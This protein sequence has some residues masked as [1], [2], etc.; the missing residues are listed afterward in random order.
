MAALGYDVTFTGTKQSV[1]TEE[2]AFLDLVRGGKT[3]KAVTVSKE[4]SRGQQAQYVRTPYI[5]KFLLYD[6]YLSVENLAKPN[7]RNSGHLDMKVGQAAPVGGLTLLFDGYDSEAK[8]GELARS[9]G[10]TVELTKGK[11]TTI[12][13]AKVTFEAFD[14]SSHEGGG[15]GNSIG[16]KLNVLYQGKSSTVIPTFNPAAAPAPTRLPTGGYVTITKIRAD[17]GGITLVFSEGKSD[18][19]IEVGAVVKVIRGADTSTVIPVFNPS[20]PHSEKA[21]VTLADGGSLTV[22]SLDAQNHAAHFDYT[23]AVMPQIATI[24]LSTKPMVNLVWLG[25]LLIVAGAV[26]AVFR[27]MSEAKKRS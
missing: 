5:E 3:I 11:S 24:A 26:V 9:M 21:T 14:M 8:A 7:A 2:L 12:D 16:A 6:L 20:A 22:T 27:R 4:M 1:G 23:P 15:M 19:D 25:F 10:K 18:P 13:G 17:I